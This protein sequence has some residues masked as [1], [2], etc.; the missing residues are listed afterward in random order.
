MITPEEAKNLLVI[1]MRSPVI[2]GSEVEVVAKLKEK[3]TKIAKP[4]LE[5][6]PKSEK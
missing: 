2:K 1:I 3:L 6:E 4:I 5:K